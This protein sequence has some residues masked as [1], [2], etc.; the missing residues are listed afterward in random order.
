MHPVVIKKAQMSS[1]YEFSVLRVRIL[2]LE[3]DRRLGL[4]RKMLIAAFAGGKI[5]VIRANGPCLALKKVAI[6]V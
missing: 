3:P 5:M 1:F 6:S 2:F 4:H